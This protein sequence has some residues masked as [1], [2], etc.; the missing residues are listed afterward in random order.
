MI[1]RLTL[2]AS[3]I[4]FI[5]CRSVKIT[6]KCCG[7]HI[8]A[9]RATEY[10]ELARI[11]FCC[12]G[13]TKFIFYTKFAQNLKLFYVVSVSAFKFLILYVKPIRSLLIQRI[14]VGLSP[15]VVLEHFIINF[16]L[17]GVVSKRD[18]LA[19]L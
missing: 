4:S 5:H 18:V 17:S 13:S 11:L 6:I 16:Y 19:L 15:T 7:I 14:P 1:Q 8:K 2:V 12:L 3:D 9:R 10:L